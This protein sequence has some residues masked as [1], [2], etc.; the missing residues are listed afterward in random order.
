MSTRKLTSHIHL[1]FLLLCGLVSPL[2]ISAQT[3][4]AL[5]LFDEPTGLYPS[6]VLENSSENDYP[7]VLGLGGRI[8][9]G[10]FGNALEVSPP[11]R[12]VFPQGEERF[13]LRPLPLPP[14][15]TV[16]PMT[17]MNAKFTALMTMGENHL[18]KEVGFVN[19]TDCDLNLGAFDWTVE[20]WFKPQQPVEQEGV[21]FEIGTG[22]RAEN[23]IVTSLSLRADQRAF[24]LVNQP[25]GIHLRIPTHVR[26]GVWQHLAF[27]YSAAAGQLQHFVDGKPQPLPVTCKLKALPHGGEAYMSVGRDG[28]WRR[29]LPGALDELRFS[30]GVVYR[31]HFTPLESFA[32][33]LQQVELQQ[34][35]PLLFAGDQD[36][37]AP[38][39]LGGRK[40]LFIDDA[41]LAEAKEVQFVVNPPH[42]AERVI[43]NIDGPF[44]KHLTVVEDEDGLIRIYNSI[45]KDYLAVRI[46]RD[47]VHFEVPDVGH[48]TIEGQKNIVIPQNV[49][50][51]GTP[52]I[53]PNGAGLER[54]KYVSGYHRRGIYLFTSPD[55]YTWTRHKSAIL[56]FRSGTQSC[57]FYDGQRRLYVSYH[58]S[59]IYH[60]PAGA[61]QRSSVVTEHENLYRTLEFKQLSQPEYLTLRERYPLRD[62][63]PW[64]LDNGPLTPGGF[65]MEFPHKFD[66][67]PQDPVGADFYVTKAQK[68]PWA[69]DTYLAF[70]IAYFHYELDGPATRQIL[71]DPERGRGSGPL[72]TQTAVSRDGL[73]WHRLPLPAYVGIGRHAGRDVKTAY[74]AHGMV[75]RGDE[76]WQYYFGETQYH[77]AWK[78]DPAGRAVYRLVQR[79][80]GFVSMDSPYDREATIITKPFVFAGS[81]LTLNIDTDAMGYAQV[82]F[83]DQGGKPIPGFSVNECIYINGDFIRTDVEWIKNMEDL[84]D[85]RVVSEDYEA[86]SKQVISS[87]DVSELQGQTV[88]LVFRMRGTKLYAMQFVHE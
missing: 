60:T 64:Y 8:V 1:L 43:D 45:H 32:P 84:G 52:F 22:P 9:Q 71:M 24:V 25:A 87:A 39:Q 31:T 62:P 79:L 12:L 3:T 75:R 17:W 14:G 16:E 88:Q 11:T 37:N 29:A 26:P 18:R 63:L 27:V 51:L 4:T 57:T 33:P 23:D 67:G 66:P 58:R 83:L 61:T 20:F 76:I 13:G 78:R 56:P 49:G 73:N 80:D 42:K 69:A 38:I 82:G 85:F 77:S 48:G 40:Y 70:P 10:K 2:S 81:R 44:R 19:P 46:S 86:F 65:G 59:G 50:G 54:W 30:K 53:D 55:G 41:L 35:P 6:S 21:V 5:W 36:S 28:K 34:E 72:E 47:G 74:I 68:Y 15:R 7:L